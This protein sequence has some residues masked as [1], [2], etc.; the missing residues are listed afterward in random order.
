MG[1]S[2]FVQIV[3]RRICLPRGYLIVLMRRRVESRPA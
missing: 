3:R 1:S 2:L